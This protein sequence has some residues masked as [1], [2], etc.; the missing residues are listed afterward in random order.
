MSEFAYNPDDYLV[1]TMRVLKAYV[2]HQLSL[3]PELDKIVDVEM[4]FPDTRSWQKDSPLQNSLVH[5]ALD[6][7]PATILGFGL[8]QVTT[9]DSVS[10]TVTTSEPQRH[11]LNYDVGVW[12]SPQSGGTT[13]RTQ[14][15]Q[16]LTNIFGTVTGRVAFNEATDGLKVVSYGGGSDVLDRVNDLPVYRTTDIT[17]EISVFSRLSQ[18]TPVGAILEANQRQEL[19]IRGEDGS[20][21]H[22]VGE[23][24]RDWT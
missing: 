14:I 23:E 20:L 22:L 12:T 16:A 6:D 18:V 2:A 17:L 7:D 19:S 8:P 1:S 15:R 10:G 5:F 11:V 4:D 21:E 9:F 24:D 3:D 13:K